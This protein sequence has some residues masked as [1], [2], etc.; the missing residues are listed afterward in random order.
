MDHQQPYLEKLYQAMFSTAYFG[1]FRICEITVTPANHTI[2]VTDVHVGK[3]KQKILFILRTSK[4]HQQSSQP[5]MVKISTKPLGSEQQYQGF[6]LYQLLCNY[7]A[8]RPQYCCVQ[9]PFFIFR[10]RSPV[11][12]E[13]LRSTLKILLAAAGF[14]PNNYLG[15]SFRIGRSSDLMKYGVSVETIK[16]LGRWKSNIV[17][18][19]IRY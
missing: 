1:L 15:H 18:S 3:N 4:T 13:H 6:C 9:E 12:A 19:Y 8:V 14:D 5:Q 16:K 17:F 2:A 7:M 11:T 10:D